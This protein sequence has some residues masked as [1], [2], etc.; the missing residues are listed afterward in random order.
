MAGDR[1]SPLDASFLHLEDA[2]SHM[3][4]A[5]ALVFAAEP[6]PYE[7]LLA[8]IESRLG[9]VPRYRQR[10]AQVPLAQARPRWVANE[11]RPALV[12]TSRHNRP[13]GGLFCRSEAGFEPATARPQPERSRRSLFFGALERSQLL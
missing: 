3:H 12:A 7:R 11:L 5:A 13:I 2:T 4:V 8:H 9:L 6:P 1:L 10:I